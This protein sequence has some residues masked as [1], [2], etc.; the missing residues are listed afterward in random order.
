MLNVG[1]LIGIAVLPGSDEIILIPSY[2]VDSVIK[3]L[4]LIPASLFQLLKVPYE[5][6]DVIAGDDFLDLVQGHSKLLEISYPVYKM[7]LLLSI[8]SVTGIRVDVRGFQQIYGA[9]VS[10][11]LGGN[12]HYL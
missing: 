9:V 4:Y 10:E 3:V 1:I 5:G 2:G 11:G 7:K 12:A 8:V 6:L